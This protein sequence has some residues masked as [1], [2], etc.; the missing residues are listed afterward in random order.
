MTRSSEKITIANGLKI[1]VLGVINTPICIAGHTFTLSLAVLRD[2]SKE[3]ILGQK[4]LN[5]YKAILN[6]SS[7]PHI[8]L[9]VPIEALNLLTTLEPEE[10]QNL[11][12]RLF[13]TTK[14][15]PHTKIE[16]AITL[17]HPCHKVSS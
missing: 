5:A 3:I 11:K 6:F 14:V 13:A 17:L 4:F 2:L 16:R 12:G 10:Q 15:Q 1:E 7:D 8:T 9:S